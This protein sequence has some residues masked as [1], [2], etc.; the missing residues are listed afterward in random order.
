MYRIRCING[1]F[2]QQQLVDYN[3]Y[4]TELI[5]PEE[6]ELIFQWI[7][8]HYG[9]YKSEDY[10]MTWDERVQQIFFLKNDIIEQKIQNWTKEIQ[11]CIK[12]HYDDSENSSGKYKIKIYL[13]SEDDSIELGMARM[14]FWNPTN[15]FLDKDGSVKLSLKKDNGD[16]ILFNKI[17]KSL[18]MEC[19]ANCFVTLS[20][21]S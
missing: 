1:I 17:Q 8:F 4:P 18:L 9:E 7:S 20:I 6:K 3:G 13:F 5:T 11:N 2:D 10:Y 19:Q 21:S 14:L 12:L 15:P 16:M